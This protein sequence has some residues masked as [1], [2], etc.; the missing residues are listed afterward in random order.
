MFKVK[1]TRMLQKMQ[2]LGPYWVRH[3]NLLSVQHIYLPLFFT[4]IGQWILRQGG[5][6]DKNG[7][8]TIWLFIIQRSETNNGSTTN[9]INS[10]RIHLI[11]VFIKKDLSSKKCWMDWARSFCAQYLRQANYVDCCRKCISNEM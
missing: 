7:S 10:A 6:L 4:K 2:V 11:P 3:S 1:K 8:C 5:I 9:E